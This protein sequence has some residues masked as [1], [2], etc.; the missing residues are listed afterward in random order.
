MFI[1]MPPSTG[2]RGLDVFVNVLTIPGF[3]PHN[4]YYI[5]R[6]IRDTAG[7]QALFREV[8]AKWGLHTAIE[9]CGETSWA[10]LETLL[11]LTDLV[12][13]DIKHM[14]RAKHRAATG[15]SNDMILENA[16]RLASTTALPLVFRTPV[17]PT[18]NDTGAAIAA[19]ARFVRELRELRAR[20]GHAGSRST[21]TYELLPFHKLASDKYAVL[22]L[23]YSASEL[24]TPGKAQLEALQRVAQDQ[25]LDVRI[26]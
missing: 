14:D 9:T 3:K 7:G 22:G 4:E 17:V 8:K 18:V 2:H 23:E 20:S 15:A 1:Y 24:P 11:G 19:I 25:G 6:D 16:C 21:I 26:G 12:M 5:D 10:V 13:M